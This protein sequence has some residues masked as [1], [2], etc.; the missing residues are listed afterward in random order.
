VSDLTPFYGTELV[1]C[2]VYTNVVVAQCCGSGWLLD[3]GW[4]K[5]Q[6]PYPLWTFPIIFSTPRELR[7]IFCVKMLKFLDADRIRDPESLW[8]WIRDPGWKYSDPG[9]TSRSGINIRIPE[10]WCENQ[11][12][13]QNEVGEIVLK[14]RDASIEGKRILDFFQISTSNAMPILLQVIIIL[15]PALPPGRDSDVFSSRGSIAL[16]VQY[17][18]GLLAESWGSSHPPP[19]SPVMSPPPMH[20]TAPPPRPQQS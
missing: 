13:F 14:S 3:P 16:T 8:P 12:L 9:F 11:T 5:N 4:V 17:Y 15:V 18:S 2:F 10:Y 6:D 20:T 19:S 7:N 1:C